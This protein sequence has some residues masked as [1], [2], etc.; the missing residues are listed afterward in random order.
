M[1]KRGSVIVDRAY[2]SAGEACRWTR[3]RAGPSSGPWGRAL[4]V[5]WFIFG[6]LT[7]LEILAIFSYEHAAGKPVDVSVS[8]MF[9]LLLFVQLLLAAM[10][11]MP[12]SRQARSPD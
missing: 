3:C 7:A 11:L 8:G 5:G 2:S 6:A 1:A 10:G 9:G 4:A 12:G